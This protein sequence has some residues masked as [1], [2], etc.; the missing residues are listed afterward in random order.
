MPAIYW[1]P[2][3]GVLLLVSYELYSVLT[4]KPRPLTLSQV[5]WLALGVTAKCPYC[6]RY[7][8]R[9]IVGGVALAFGMG[10]L[11]GHFFA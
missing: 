10:F 7:S 5:M 1:W 9:R 3:A 11:M 8:K 6:G 2:L 4:A